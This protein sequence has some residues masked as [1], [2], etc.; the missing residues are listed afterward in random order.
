MCKWS[1]YFFLWKTNLG[2]SLLYFLR[3]KILGPFSFSE[4][5]TRVPFFSPKNGLP[6][7]EN[8]G[9]GL[10]LNFE[11]SLRVEGGDVGG[12]SIDLT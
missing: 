10:T 9:P 12:D 1:K 5:K 7:V 8:P 2:S 11:R 3:K 6:P 4:K